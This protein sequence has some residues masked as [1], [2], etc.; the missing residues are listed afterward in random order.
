MVLTDD[1][2]VRRSRELVHDDYNALMIRFGPSE[3]ASDAL[4]S[5]ELYPRKVVMCFLWGRR[6]AGS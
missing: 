6:V 2:F 5:I 4:V 1:N 3:R